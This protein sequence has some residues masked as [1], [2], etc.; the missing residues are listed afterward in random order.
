MPVKLMPGCKALELLSKKETSKQGERLIKYCEKASDVNYDAKEI[1]KLR[2][3]YK[4]IL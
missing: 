2:E 4:D 3:Q 1:L